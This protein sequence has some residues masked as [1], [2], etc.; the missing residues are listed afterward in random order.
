MGSLGSHQTRA[1]KNTCH[2]SEEVIGRAD[3]IVGRV[4]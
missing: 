3:Y 4:Q 1:S 2:D